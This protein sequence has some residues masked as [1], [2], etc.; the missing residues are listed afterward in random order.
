MLSTKEQLEPWV[1]IK[2]VAAHTGISKMTLA[3]MADMKQIPSYELPCGG[4]R[5][6]RR[7]K[8]SLVDEALMQ[9]MKKG[10]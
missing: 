1:D 7:F 6:H 9:Q 8:L 2:V 5:V 10:A 4:K 3:K